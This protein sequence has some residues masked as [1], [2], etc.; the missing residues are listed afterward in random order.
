[1]SKHQPWKRVFNEKKPQ[2]KTKQFTKQPQ[3]TSRIKVVSYIVYPIIF[4]ALSWYFIVQ[5]AYITSFVIWMFFLMILLLKDILMRNVLNSLPLIIF[6]A[7]MTFSI[8]TNTLRETLNIFYLIPLGALVL[9]VKKT[10]VQY[11]TLAVSLILILLFLIL[12]FI[13]FL[14]FQLVFI[15]MILLIFLPPVIAL[16]IESALTKKGMRK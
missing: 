9:D 13:L 1:M 16:K 6:V 3:D 10:P 8:E 4:V 2:K 7:Y 11:G 15:L 14:P 12:D 5:S